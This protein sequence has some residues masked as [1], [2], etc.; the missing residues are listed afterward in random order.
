M[1]NNNSCF[2]CGKAYHIPE[3]I[4]TL[5]AWPDYEKIFNDHMQN[6]GIYRLWKESN[7]GL[8]AYKEHLIEN[9]NAKTN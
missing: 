3:P 4:P 8:M 6:C 1:V 2:F 7:R 9:R 5:G